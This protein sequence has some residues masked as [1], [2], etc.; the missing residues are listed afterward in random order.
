MFSYYLFLIFIKKT[1]TSNQRER[2]FTDTSRLL[3]ERF[4]LMII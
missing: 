3:K 2:I 4:Y 1:N